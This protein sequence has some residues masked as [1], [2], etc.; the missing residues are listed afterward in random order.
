[1]NNNEL[2]INGHGYDN[3]MEGIGEVAT[4]QTGETEPTTSSTTT[5]STTTSEETSGGGFDW[6]SMMGMFGSGS[7]SSTSS[8][9]PEPTQSSWSTMFEANANQ[10]TSQQKT[11]RAVIWGAVIV[12]VIGMIVAGFFLMK[13]K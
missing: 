2:H 4:T 1:M 11:Q 12:L 8:P 6:T 10:T 5:S 7:G 13:K 3:W 9:T